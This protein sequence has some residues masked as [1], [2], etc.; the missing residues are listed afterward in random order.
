MTLYFRSGAIDETQANPC[1]PW[2]SRSI[3]KA[4][5][6]NVRAGWGSANLDQVIA[7]FRDK[8]FKEE[9]EKLQK[10]KEG[11]LPGQPNYEEPG[12]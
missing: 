8:A 11:K 3:D 1:H 9:E 5:P 4:S 6:Y 10:M 7:H 2:L 12:R